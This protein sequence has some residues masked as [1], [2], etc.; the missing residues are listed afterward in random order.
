LKN[1]FDKY[2]D[3]N[4]RDFLKLNNEGSEYQILALKDKLKTVAIEFHS[5]PENID[6][7]NKFISE[8]KMDIVGFNINDTGFKYKSNPKY[9]RIVIYQ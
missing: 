3:K 7:I 2:K 6:I 4:A 5:A 9:N 1:I 8:I